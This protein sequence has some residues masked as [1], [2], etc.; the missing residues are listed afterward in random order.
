MKGRVFFKAKFYHINGALDHVFKG[1][2]CELTR[3]QF[4]A[5]NTPKNRTKR[6]SD[7]TPKIGGLQEKMEVGVSI[8]REGEQDKQELE[9]RI[10]ELTQMRYVRKRDS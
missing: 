9:N 3:P 1:D 2:G 5:K 8:I 7:K 10:T 4:T 6:D